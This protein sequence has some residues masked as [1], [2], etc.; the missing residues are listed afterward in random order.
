MLSKFVNHEDLFWKL[1][2]EAT[3]KGK[4]KNLEVIPSIHTS[5]LL[6]T[7]YLPLVQEIRVRLKHIY[8]DSDI[9]TTSSV[10]R[11]IPN[12]FCGSLSKTDFPKLEGIRF[13]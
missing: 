9:M 8:I 1:T 11:D 4:L 2:L 13:G 3:R 10:L 6:E 12:T 7:C 5:E